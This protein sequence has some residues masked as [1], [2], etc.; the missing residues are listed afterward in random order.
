MTQADNLSLINKAIIAEQEAKT[1]ARH[2]NNDVDV[3]TSAGAEAALKASEAERIKN[4]Q[5]W[6]DKSNIGQVG[7]VKDSTPVSLPSKKRR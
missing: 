7:A 2:H 4:A 1:R 5:A 6:L 3:L